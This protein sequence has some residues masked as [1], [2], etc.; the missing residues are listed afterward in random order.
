VRK[1]TRTFSTRFRLNRQQSFFWD[2]GPNAWF[3]D[4]SSRLRQAASSK[5]T[6]RRPQH[7]PCQL[8]E[9]DEEEQSEG[10]GDENKHVD[11]SETPEP[12]KRFDVPLAEEL[13]ESDELHLTINIFKDIILIPD[14]KIQ[15]LCQ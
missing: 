11:K 14:E 12:G 3:I 15:R 6:E 5:R 9:N 4:K 13:N 8:V 10:N 7:R 2:I 1:Y